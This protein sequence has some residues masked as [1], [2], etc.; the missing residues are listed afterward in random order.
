MNS[1]SRLRDWCRAGPWDPHFCYKPIHVGTRTS[2]S[3]ANSAFIKIP[4]CGPGPGVT[5]MV[6]PVSSRGR[7]RG[8]GFCGTRH[9][10]H[11]EVTQHISEPNVPSGLGA[12]EDARPRRAG[13][14][15]R[16]GSGSRS[17]LYCAAK[18]RTRPPVQRVTRRW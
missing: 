11:L 10:P 8:F 2:A 16:G 12:E 14:A 17:V 6:L 15:P 1:V 18:T 9:V 5:F 4:L 7:F 3:R 13:L